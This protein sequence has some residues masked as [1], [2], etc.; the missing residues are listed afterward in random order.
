M[1][2]ELKANMG[3]QAV[4]GAVLGAVGYFGNKMGMSAE[5]IAVV[6]PFVLTAMAWV[7]TKIGDKGTTAIFRV[8]QEVVKAQS[9]QKKSK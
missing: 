9:E 4:K 6:M 3:D 7:S 2:P 1:K 8:V 5:Q